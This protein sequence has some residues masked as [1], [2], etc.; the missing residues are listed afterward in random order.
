MCDTAIRYAVY[1]IRYSTTIAVWTM[2]LVSLGRTV[3]FVRL[4]YVLRIIRERVEYAIRT[5][6]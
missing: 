3:D 2:H 5:H 1:L 6:Q 4:T